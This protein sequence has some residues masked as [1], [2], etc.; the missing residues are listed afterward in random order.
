MTIPDSTGVEQALLGSILLDNSKLPLDPAL[1]VAD[2]SLDTHRLIY[3]CIAAM[4]EDRRPVD[5]VTVTF[6]LD[7]LGQLDRCSGAEYIASLIDHAMP[8]NIH[9]YVRAV[10]N[11]AVER[12]AARQIELLTT[13][14]ATASQFKLANL[15][16][17]AQDL[18]AGLKRTSE[19]SPAEKI[20]QFDQIP[21]IMTMEIQPLNWLVD[22]MIARNTMTL[23][24]GTD[25][26]AKTLLAQKMAIS[27][28]SGADF[29]GRRCQ[30][31]PVLYL[32]YENPDFAVRERLDLMA[33]GPIAG[34]KVWGTWLADQPPQIGNEL[35]LAI[36]KETK[37]L[38]IVDP[39]LYAHGADENSSTEMS[40]V[41]QCLRYCA[42]AGGAVII[43]HH[44]AKTEGSTGRG[45]SAIKG[46][47]DVAY[48]QEMSDETG[49]ITL[50]CT[51]N[52]FGERHCVTIRPD[53]DEGSFTV[54]D[55]A[56]FTKRAGDLETLGKIIA[57]TPGLTQNAI[58]KKSGM[59][60]SR[61]VTL[62]KAG[63]D[64]FWE[65]RREG[66]SLLYF[67]IVPETGN[68]VGTKGT[69]QGLGACS[70]VPPLY[71][72]EQGT[73]PPR[74]QT[75]VPEQVTQKPNGKT[76]PR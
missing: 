32:D 66:N 14:C 72:G 70:S 59:K 74:P 8:E 33:G 22:G 24:T 46:A 47:V 7:Q 19:N 57:E 45:S 49:L 64:G 42:A 60:K 37:P 23:L 16:Q 62:L 11:A 68:N 56:Q 55:S 44:P 75:S 34:L 6:E 69:G 1:S 36:A 52:R 65:E 12:A 39:F 2:F 3:S 31:A 28:A 48:L 71:K 50:T 67:P 35:L 15:Q 5:I 73:I 18:L 53:Y 63:N 9:T 30:P 58:Y 4:L 10:R 51:K 43:I 76:L 26:T 13:T 54:T 41:M 25:G 20:R 21:D 27:V 40:G 61:L 29:L 38:I 17:Q